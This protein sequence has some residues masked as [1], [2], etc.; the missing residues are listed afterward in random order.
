MHVAHT[1]AR[2]GA[3]QPLFFDMY[4]NQLVVPHMYTAADMESYSESPGYATFVARLV[5][6]ALLPGSPWEA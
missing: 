2:G 4:M 6:P 5:A 3:S 1:D